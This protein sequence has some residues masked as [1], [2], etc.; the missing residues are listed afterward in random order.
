MALDCNHTAVG[1]SWLALVHKYGTPEFAAAFAADAVF[2]ASVLTAPLIGPKAIGTYF[3]ATT[4]GLYQEISFTSETTVGRTTFYQ[5]MG[6]AFD[7]QLNG[8]TVVTKNEAGLI[9]NVRLFHSPYPVVLR[10]A[11]EL[12]KRLVRSET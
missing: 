9:Q 12:V 4:A 6:R 11:A 3:G 8:L 1:Q 7:I 2:D 5:W 10:F